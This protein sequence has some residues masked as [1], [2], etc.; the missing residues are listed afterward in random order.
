M[1]AIELVLHPDSAYSAPDSYT[2]LPSVPGANAFDIKR[3]SPYPG[4][5]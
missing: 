2:Q 5:L 3:S 1:N 4:N